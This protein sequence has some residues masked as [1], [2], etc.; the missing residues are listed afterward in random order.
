M[1]KLSISG[2]RKCIGEPL[3]KS[4]IFLYLT[5]IVRQFSMNFADGRPS[6]YKGAG[7][8]KKPPACK[9]TFQPR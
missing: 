2:R 3:T 6:T 7:T 4:Q 1:L 5:G 9:I 8:F